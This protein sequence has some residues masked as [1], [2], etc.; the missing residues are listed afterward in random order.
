M[1]QKLKMLK[2][3]SIY[4]TPNDLLEINLAITSTISFLH[5]S[6]TF[7]CQK[8]LLYLKDMLDKKNNFQR[9]QYI[10]EGNVLILILALST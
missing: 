9:H 10:Y 4:D 5:K 8:Q 1:Y 6:L 7:K 3:F 2:K